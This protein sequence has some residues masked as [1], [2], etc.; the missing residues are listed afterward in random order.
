M[1]DPF[2]CQTVLRKQNALTV[3]LCLICSLLSPVAAA[4]SLALVD[5]EILF[6]GKDKWRLTDDSNQTLR[7]LT[8]TLQGFAG[9]LSIRIIG[10]TDDGGGETVNQRLSQ[11]RADSIKRHFQARF[12]EAHIM[13]LGAGESIPFATNHNDAGRARNQRVQIQVIATGSVP[14]ID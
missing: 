10:H 2:H 3:L 9:I 5:A 7:D 11:Q 12:P 6:V 4:D 14:G 13:S 1:T 8:S